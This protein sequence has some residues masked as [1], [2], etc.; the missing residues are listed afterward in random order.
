M[1]WFV[2]LALLQ[3][4]ITTGA[5]YLLLAIGLLIVFSVTRVIFV[6]QGDL[7]AFGTLTV[8]ALQSG[9]LPGTLWLLDGVSTL[10]LIASLFRGRRAALRGILAW[11][12]YPAMVTAIAFF[13]APREVPAISIILALAIVTPMG[14]LI[15]RFAFRP[16]ANA[17]VLALLILAVAL[18]FVLIGLGLVFFGPEEAA[19]PPITDVSFDFGSLNVS[20]Q[21]LAVLACCAVLVLG[22]RWFFGSTIHGKALRAAASDRLGARLVGIDASATGALAFGLASF[23][24]ALAGVLIGAVTPISY[25]AGFDIGLKGFVAAIMGGL[26]SYPMAAAGAVL[27][28]VLESLSSFWASAYH[29]VIVFTLLIPILVWL[30]LRS[31]SPED[32]A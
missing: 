13:L 3:D 12:L 9:H 6:P 30:S 32:R 17:S 5:I 28:G 2:F 29:E 8:A 24:A 19:A 1:D 26:V 11:G 15:W 25:D 18:H 14:P 27:V 22:L 16:V 7:L 21:T 23:I 31:G 4:G 20:G 10:A